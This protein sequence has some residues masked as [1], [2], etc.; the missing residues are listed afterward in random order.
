MSFKSPAAAHN[1]ASEASA[2]TREEYFGGVRLLMSDARVV[3]LLLNDARA[4]VIT[5]LFGISGPNSALVTIIALGLA[6]DTAHRKLAR[7]LGGPGAPS[8]GD[9]ALGASAVSESVRWAAGAQS[10]ETPM[11]APL[12]LLAAAGPVLGATVRGIRASSHRAHAGFDH[13]YG[14]LIRPSRRRRP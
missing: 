6:A 3:Y 1:G 9:A 8:I 11:L 13:R 14:H 5:R 7:V 12:L 10:S 2:A 4:R